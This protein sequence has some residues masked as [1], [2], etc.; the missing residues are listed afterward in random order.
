[1]ATGVKNIIVEFISIHIKV[2]VN[3]YI[4]KIAQRSEE[5]DQSGPY[6]ILRPSRVI[7][8]GRSAFPAISLINVLGEPRRHIRK[9][10]NYLI[11]QLTRNPICFS[12]DLIAARPSSTFLA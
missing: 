9:A 12:G 1:M 3:I 8:D 7:L 6:K 10:L 5:F 11:R 4:K 2:P